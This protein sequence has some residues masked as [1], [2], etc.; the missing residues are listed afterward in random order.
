MDQG[1]EESRDQVGTLAF[2]RQS[3]RLIML[4]CFLISSVSCLEK[5]SSVSFGSNNNPFGSVRLVDTQPVTNVRTHRIGFI[6]D[7]AVQYSLF[8][9]TPCRAIGAQWEDIVPERTI[10]LP[11]QD[12]YYTISVLFRNENSFV[13][14]CQVIEMTL[15]RSPP[16]IQAAATVATHSL[17]SETPE[18]GVSSYE[19]T[20]ARLQSIEGRVVQLSNG[21]GITPWLGLGKVLNGQKIIGLSLVD[22][23]LYAIEVR[24]IDEAGNSGPAFRLAPFQAGPSFI[25][26]AADYGVAGTYSY[27]IKLTKPAFDDLTV[28]F[29]TEAVTA[30]EGLDYLPLAGTKVLAAGFA[31]FD[32]SISVNDVLQPGP[33]RTFKLKVKHQTGIFSA[34]EGVATIL[35]P[36]PPAFETLNRLAVKGLP[37]TYDNSDALAVDLSAA[38][39]DSYHYKMISILNGSCTD[40]AGYSEAILPTKLIT[41][42]LVNLEIAAQPKLCILGRKNKRIISLWEH[43]WTKYKVRSFLNFSSSSHIYREATTGKTAF[44]LDQPQPTPVVISYSVSGT[45]TIDDLDLPIGPGQITIPANE[46]VAFIN[47]SVKRN[48]QQTG[49]RTLDISITGVNNPMVNYYPQANQHIVIEDSDGPS[50]MIRY[51]K[52]SVGN[53][54]TCAI[55]SPGGQVYCWGYNY[56][57][58]LGD[59]TNNQSA[60]PVKLSDNLSYADISTGGYFSCGITTAGVLRCWGRNSLSQLG[61]VGPDAWTPVTVDTENYKQISVG[62]A[63]ACGLTANDQV[64]CWGENLWGKTGVNQSSGST[65]L[66]QVIDGGAKYRWISAGY[67]HTC[68][69][70]SS[71]ILKCWGRNSNGQLGINSTIDKLLPMTVGSGYSSVVAGRFTTCAQK[72]NGLWQCWG[73]NDT[74]QVGDGTNT[75]KLMPVTISGN[76]SQIALGDSY[77]CGLQNKKIF[78]WGRNS[79]GGIG[80]CCDVWWISPPTGLWTDA[81]VDYAQIEMGNDH[82]CGVTTDGILKCWGGQGDGALGDGVTS[83]AITVPTF[84]LV[85]GTFVD[86]RVRYSG[87]CGLDSVGHLFC[88]GSGGDGSL[89]NGRISL[90]NPY[91]TKVLGED[92]FV[93]IDSANPICGVTITGIMKCWG[94][95]FTAG[96]EYLLGSIYGKYLTNP[97]VVDS[98][99]TYSKV[100]GQDSTIC[101]ITTS[102]QLKCWGENVDGEVGDGSRVDKKDPVLID[103]GLPYKEVSVGFAHTC[104]IRDSGELKCWGWNVN[105]K[106]GVPGSN[107]YFVTP[108]DV[109]SGEKY[110]NVSTGNEN[111]CGVT[112]KN[113]LK[114]WGWNNYGQIGDGTKVTATSPQVID[115][116]RPYSQVSV[117]QFHVCAVSTGG[118]LYCWGS[119]DYGILGIPSI[120]ESLTPAIVPSSEKYK[121]VSVTGYNT[122]AITTA[123]RIQCWG[124]AGYG[125]GVGEGSHFTPQ[126]VLPPL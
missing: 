39:I 83:S 92:K 22:G 11:D 42:S 34:Q 55:S 73:A 49:Q 109:D 82:S 107:Q 69:V 71:Y 10:E 12:G 16:V 76:F 106:V 121:K 67:T 64:K 9:N 88:W 110:I 114:C 6:A 95:N 108:Q 126:P 93:S 59:G 60:V 65:A 115:A 81:T 7:T 105:S 80:S 84:V 8:V 125:L 45:A 79:S 47:F 20:F 46:T 63:H 58:G 14:D 99:T 101:G 15:D 74:Y 96:G 35:A 27:T 86:V 91:P 100:S 37:A 123:G 5:K 119:N 56:Y 62:F 17:L 26:Q 48:P 30:L 112:D 66:P 1:R 117:G 111:T 31:S 75:D 32:V 41:D 4:L 23:S 38:D 68:G 25:L 94:Y 57:G 89:G 72:S 124:Y 54:H 120:K 116:G 53:Y 122:C 70:T 104:A 18:F 19:D 44:Q 77:S 85:A 118:D 90:P 43:S 113:V 102:K 40:F 98:S 51:S 61:V 52:V 29:Q 33:R 28:N 24:A 78:C 13:S 103:G 50:S 21:T 36:P 3:L 97:A 87:V 2:F